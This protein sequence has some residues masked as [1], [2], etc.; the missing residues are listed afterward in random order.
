[1][2]RF[3]FST[4][5]MRNMDGVHP[6]LVDVLHTALDFGVIDFVV[7]EGVRTKEEQED[8]YAQGRTKP[9]KKVTWTLNSKH[10]VQD[11]GF[12][13]A[14]D[15]VPYPTYFEDTEAF[16][17]LAGVIESAASLDGVDLKWGGAWKSKD[18]PHFELA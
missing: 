1:M 18:L 13:H 7:I 10:L 4:R 11:T 17:K 6:M 12:G 3:N 16:Y 15:I 2:S 8:L 5:S 14:V 9:G